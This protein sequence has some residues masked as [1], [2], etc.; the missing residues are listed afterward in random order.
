MY[1]I[2]VNF[3]FFFFLP[4]LSANCR[5]ETGDSGLPHCEMGPKK[6]TP[7]TENS[8]LHGDHDGKDDKE[9]VSK[10]LQKEMPKDS[11]L[12]LGTAKDTGAE[13]VVEEKEENSYRE[14]PEESSKEQESTKA[15]EANV[16]VEEASTEMADTVV[17][18]R[19]SCEETMSML[20]EQ[21]K[22]GLPCCEMDS[23]T[24]MSQTENTYLA[25]DG[26]DN[27]DDEEEVSKYFK[28][29]EIPK[30]DPLSQ[31]TVK[32]T[33][34]EAIIKEQEEN[35]YRKR[36]EESSKEQE[37]STKTGEANMAVEEASVEMAD[38][39]VDTNVE[40]RES[41]E[42]TLN[43]PKSSQETEPFD[44]VNGSPTGE[45]SDWNVNREDGCEA[46][47]L[48]DVNTCE[49]EHAGYTAGDFESQG[50]DTDTEI[51]ADSPVLSNS[52]SEEVLERSEKVS[53]SECSFF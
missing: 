31:D 9:K 41:D 1:K 21:G 25:G 4:N 15:G 17:E 40:M 27:K 48:E 23:E 51:G 43:V 45:E 2:N 30:D 8:C 33:G 16:S 32:A 50:S 20:G 3:P 53:E 39:D 11:P 28:Q 52:Q 12:N 35:S 36:L 29:K 24:Q 7:R 37:Q 26:H 19:E 13:A 49:K 38:T 47:N 6:R 46:N 14:K 34:A 42:E 5:K 44:A 10:Y 18:M 22:S